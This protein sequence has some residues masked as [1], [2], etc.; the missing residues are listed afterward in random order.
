MIDAQAMSQMLQARLRQVA[1]VHFVGI[2]GSGMAGIAEV[3]INL[4]YTVSGSDQREGPSV[5][6]L[7]SLGADVRI[8]HDPAAVEGADVVV[9]SSAVTADNPEIAAALATR[10]PVIRRAEMLAELMRFRFGIAIAGT[11]G[12][13]TTTSLTATVLAAGHLDPTYVIGGLLKSSGSNA[14][15]GT[16]PYLVAEADESDASFLHLTPMISVVTNVDLDHMDTYDHDPQRLY[17]SY[18]EFLQQLPFYG[19]ALLCADDPMLMQLRD[20]IGRPTLSYG[21]SPEADYRAVNLRP[22]AGRIHFDLHTPQQQVVPVELALPGRHNVQNALAAL[23][24]ACELGLDPAEVAPALA[25]FKGIGRRCEVLGNMA[26]PGGGEAMVI[27]DYGHHP[28]ELQA[29]LSAVREAW[30]SRRC[31]LVFQPHRYSR[32]RDLFDDFARVLSSTQALLLTDVYAAGETPLAQ[33]DSRSLARAIRL[34]G[35]V[36]PVLVPALD[37]VPAQLA[38]LARDGD[39]VL[40]MGAGNISGLA[41]RLAKQGVP[42]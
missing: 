18:V 32:T 30:P 13:T 19:L 2:G 38:N 24:V 16:G 11:H 39:I 28:E 4:G 31:V 9:R 17:Y 8:G 3:L 35:Q 12:K 5:Q 27:D 25:T 33:A 23:S 40:C 15:L 1:K 10:T 21:F 7:R 29:T 42:T 26:L 41:Q 36:E 20:D 14:A 6:R 34:R 37:D 22:D